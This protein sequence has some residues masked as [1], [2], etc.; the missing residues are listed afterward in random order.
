[1]KYFKL[2]FVA[3]LIWNVFTSE[4]KASNK[5]HDLIYSCAEAVAIYD[6]KDKRHLYTAITTSLSEALRAGYCRGVLVEFRRNSRYNCYQ[7]NWLDQ[8]RIIAEYP[9]TDKQSVN[10]EQLLRKSCD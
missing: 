10:V 3:F 4:V 7:N 9:I 2:I 8:A 6:K 5:A 1:M